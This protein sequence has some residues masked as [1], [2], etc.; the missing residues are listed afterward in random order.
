I[1]TSLGYASYQ[2]VR[3]FQVT[4]ATARLKLVGMTLTGTF[5]YSTYAGTAALVQNGAT[6][7][8]DDC[9]IVNNTAYNSGVAVRSMGGNVTI[10]RSVFT[11]NTDYTDG[12]VYASDTSSYAGS[13]TIGQSIFALNTAYSHPNPNVKATSVVAKTN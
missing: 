7:E 4:G 9:A 3:G 6:L 11:G 1:T 8:I 12:A 5:T 2:E 10:L 13:L